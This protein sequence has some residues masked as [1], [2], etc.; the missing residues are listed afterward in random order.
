[1]ADATA[2]AAFLRDLNTLLVSDLNDRTVSPKPGVT[3]EASSFIS[4]S[5][6]SNAVLDDGVSGTAVLDEDDLSSD[7]ATQ[8]ATQQSIKA[9]VDAGDSAIPAQ[10]NQ[11]AVEAETNEDTYV[12][13]DLLK[14]S[15]GVAKVW[16]AWEQ[17]GAHG[18]IGS[19]NMT[20]V[21]DGGAAGDTDHLWA[22]DFADALYAVMGMAGATTSAELVMFAALT[23]IAVGGVTTVT[24]TLAGSGSDSAENYLV[25]FGDQ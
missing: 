15:P 10:A 11:A 17:T 24:S 16:V 9:Y 8:I 22:T 12:P 13:P 2:D 18:I 23:T 3:L 19:Y 14:H 4:G 25:A 20:S 21:T 6:F 7:S 5:V 1:M